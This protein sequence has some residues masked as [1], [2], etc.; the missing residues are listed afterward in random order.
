MEIEKLC[1]EDFTSNKVVSGT[2]TIRFLR[3]GVIFLNKSAVNHLKL[4][5]HKTKIL[6]GV[7]FF[8]DTKNHVDFS[9]CKDSKGWV[10][11]HAGEKSGCVIFN[12]AIFA[13]YIIK[14]TWEERIVHA[15]DAVKPSSLSFQ[16]ALLPLD[17]DKNK[18]I[19]A[20]LRKKE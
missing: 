19:Y 3:S 11:R 10:L 1:K 13:R 12:N 18:D 20:L 4:F 14:M 17:D 2:P 9:I 8:Q 5:D 7:S 15:V 16:I 6:S